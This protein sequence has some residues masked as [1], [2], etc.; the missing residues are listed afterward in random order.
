[1]S[2]LTPK[3]KVLVITGPTASGKSDI[4]VNLAQRFNGEIISAD[5]RQVY[6]G[7]NLG[8]GK[9]AIPEMKGVPHHL[10]D[11]ADPKERFSVANWKKLALRSIQNILQRGKLPIIC[12]GTGFYISSL[13][14]G[15]EFPDIVINQDEQKE[16]EL[17]TTEELFEMLRELDPKR[18]RT[19]E[20]KNKRR[21]SR[22]ILM[23]KV[24]GYV[25][26][27]S[28][29]RPYYDFLF[30]GITISDNE[31][32]NR[33]HKRLLKRLGAGM[34]EEVKDLHEKGLSRERL[35]ELGLEYRYV[36]D[37]IHGK[38]TKSQLIETLS[39]KIWQYARR[40]KT[41]WRKEKRI[42]WFAPDDMAGIIAFL[43][44]QIEKTAIH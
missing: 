40:Q 37:F 8:S 33:I 26:E 35:R 16:L 12:G 21:L 27:I 1:M 9:I 41:W 11:T 24:F 7:M 42:K 3:D 2:Q 6:I 32:R 13:I 4:A 43:E 31:L 5:S 39:T 22:A 23:A 34:I 44:N 38:L 25:P 18:A 29:A 36:S 30:I 19:I 14:D 28:K 10:L 15:I 20:Q 17:K